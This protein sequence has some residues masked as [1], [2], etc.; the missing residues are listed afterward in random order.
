[1]KINKNLKSMAAL[2]RVYADLYQSI[3][4]AKPGKSNSLQLLKGDEVI[5]LYLRASH[6]KLK[7]ES[8]KLVA[9]QNIRPELEEREIEAWQRLIK[10]LTH[11]IINSVR[12]PEMVR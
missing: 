10:V 6:F 8:I 9:I 4:T 3:L 1:M 2:Q 7:D 12:R 5:S 11:E